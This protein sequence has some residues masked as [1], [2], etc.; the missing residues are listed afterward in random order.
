LGGAIQ[1]AVALPALAQRPATSTDTIRLSLEEAVTT[2]LRVGDEVRLSAAQADIAEAQYSAARA[3]LLPQLRI[4]AAYTHTL[5]NARSNAINAVFN[6]PRV[7][8]TNANLS[9]ALFQGGRL[10]STAR[11]ASSLAEASRLNAQEQRALFTVTVQRAYLDALLAERLAELQQTNLQLASS[12]LAQVQQFQN[13]GRAAQYDVLR[14]K[15]ERAN[16][17]PIAIQATNDRELAHLELKRLLN[18]PLDQPVVLTSTIDPAAAQTLVATYLDTAALPDRAALRS[19]AG[20]PRSAPRDQCG[21]S[22]IHAECHGILSNGLS[23]IP[24][25]GLRLSGPP[26]R[27]RYAVLRGGFDVDSRMPERGMVRGP[28]HGTAVLVA[29]VR[30]P[31]RKERPRVSA[32]RDAGR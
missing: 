22:R 6:Q 5:E 4:N 24:T 1:L 15:V 23:S 13:A 30:W 10:I 3:S 17:E 31:A 8:S 25:P 16:I 19:A 14:A 9:Q 18:L 20:R 26:R 27:G 12:R 11:A 7:Y 2:G 28:Q 32:C 29:C 21:A